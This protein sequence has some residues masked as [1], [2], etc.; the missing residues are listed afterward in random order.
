MSD[1]LTILS[2][3]S[4]ARKQNITD[5][6]NIYSKRLMSFI[7]QRVVRESDAEDIL[8]DVFFQMIQTIK[9]I[10]DAG[11][12]LF[13][14]ARNKITDQKR[15][16]K[17]DLFSDIYEEDD[18]DE[19]DWKEIFYDNSGNPETEYL[20]SLFWEELDIS[21]NELPVEQREVFIL[22]ELE[23]VPFKEIAAL[24]GETVNTLLSRKRYAVLHLRNRLRVLHD[25]LLNY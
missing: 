8:Q 19:I 23:G 17:P 5:I 9:P 25:E 15:K 11:A 21:L 14:V 18:E 2:E 6:I 24:T 22:N 7:R 4:A 1:T 16:H 12:W 13:A 10:E 20:R 3:M